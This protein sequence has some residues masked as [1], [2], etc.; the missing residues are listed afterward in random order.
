MRGIYKITNTINNKCYIGKSEDL[1]KRLKYHTDTLVRGSNKN[2]HMQNAYN[3]YGPGT[4]TVEILEDL[5]DDVDINEREK[6]WISFYQ[7]SDD[8]YGYNRTKGGDGGNSY[9]DCMAEEEREEHYKK[10]KEIRTGENNPV[11]G[12]RLYNDGI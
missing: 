4:F 12:K 11:Y 6:Y 5:D 2:K 1:A 8:R 7:S 9:V 3:M 10:H